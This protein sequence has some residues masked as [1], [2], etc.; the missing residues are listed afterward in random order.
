[1]IEILQNHAAGFSRLTTRKFTN[2]SKV[3]GKKISYENLS[4]NIYRNMDDN[5]GADN[6][7]K[8]PTT[9]EIQCDSDKR[10]FE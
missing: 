10:G 1:M 2:R 7:Q 4:L 8:A 5:M 3:H 6:Y 9:Q